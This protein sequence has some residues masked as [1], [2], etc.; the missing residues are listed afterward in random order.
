MKPAATAS[1]TDPGTIIGLMRLANT[2]TRQLG[3]LF[4]RAKITP[5]Q[6]FLLNEL[7]ASETSPTLAGLARRLF[8]SKQNVTGMVRRLEELGLLKRSDDP[9]DLRSNRIGL[10]RRGS[11]VVDRIAPAYGA[12]VDRLLCALPPNDR[13]L[14]ERSIERLTETLQSFE[15][16]R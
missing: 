13:K 4:H 7:A 5:Q 10:T 9:A 8:V 16:E 11:E 15:S 6:W 3:P 12:W 2:L 14:L 1:S